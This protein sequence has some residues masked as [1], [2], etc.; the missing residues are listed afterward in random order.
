MLDNIGLPGILLL[1]LFSVP[2]AVAAWW[3]AP[4]M[5]ARRWLWFL[6]MVLPFINFFTVY[7]LFIRALGAILDKLNAMKPSEDS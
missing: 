4:K 6:L 2:F 1:V 7:F 3:I 5:G